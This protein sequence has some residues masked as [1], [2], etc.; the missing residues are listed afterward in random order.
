M[1]AKAERRTLAAAAVA[2][3]AVFLLLRFC[4]GRTEAESPAPV[5]EEE[6]QALADFEDELRRDS[7]EWAAKHQYEKYGYS[8]G[9]RTP[10][11]FPFDPNTADSATL[12]RL[13]L[14]PW[15]AANAMKYRKRG[16]RWRSPEDFRR[17]Y[18][19][20]E[21]DYSRLR[22]YIRIAPSAEEIER[23]RRQE[24]H[25]SLRATWP[26]K[27]A[28]GTVLDLNEADTTALKGIPGIGTWR[29]QAITRYRERLGGFISTDQL[30]EIDDLPEGIE[31]WF[32]V[33][34][35]ARPRRM[36]VNKAT[37]KQLVR[38]PYLNY[39]QVKEV[40]NFIRLQ[41]PLRSWEDLRLSP[42]FTERDF[43][44]LRPYFDF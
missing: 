10:E 41:G 11:S 5:S 3:A 1:L 38:H 29:A 34:S 19:L 43:E 44:R 14:H 40:A 20:S 23:E 12:V 36:N 39:E 24:R 17:L 28:E 18:G 33:S 27:Y 42:H 21:A 25:D 7:A 26:K 13:G 30:K 4:E 22:P 2:L 35:D 31:R 37:F 15:Q 32:T 16:G 8:T 6:W 9:R